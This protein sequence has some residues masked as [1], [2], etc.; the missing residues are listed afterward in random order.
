[1][2]RFGDNIEYI[3]LCLLCY[4]ITG[5]VIPVGIVGILSALPN[6][7]FTLIGGALSEYREKKKIM[8]ICEIARGFFILKKNV[9]G[10]AML[11]SNLI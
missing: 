7:L 8:I 5:S 1:M 3:A 4:K 11:K 9:V 10:N 2:S 6:I